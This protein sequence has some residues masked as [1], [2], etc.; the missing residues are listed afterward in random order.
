[1]LCVS[2]DDLSGHPFVGLIE[3]WK[4][5]HHPPETTSI[6]LV[7]RILASVIQAPESERD[8]IV[9]KYS[10]FMSSTRSDD[11]SL[12]HKLLGEEFLDSLE[13]LRVATSRCFTQECV[14]PFLT[15]E[16]FRSLFALVGR[17][18]QGIASSPWSVYVKNT[19]KLPLS[20]KAREETEGL[21]EAV[22]SALDF[23]MP[24]LDSEGSGLFELQSMINHSCYP[25]AEVSFPFNNHTL[26]V[27]ALRRIEPGEEIFIS[28]IDEC[29][30]GSSRHTRQKQL[31][32]NYLFACGCRKCEEQKY[33]PDVTSEEEMSDEDD[34]EGGGEEDEDE[35]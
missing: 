16:G 3:Q 13:G 27:R 26:V 23:S 33:D 1:M 2:G 17:N 6:M 14:Q 11:D 32:E 31:R 35:G 22:Y 10:S 7:C 19:A 8:E 5:M 24:F 9:G 29:S 20:D 12:T 4:Q 28:Y 15:G 30:L 21:I 34:D 25:N 18:G